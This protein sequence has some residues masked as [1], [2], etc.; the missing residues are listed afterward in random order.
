LSDR[1]PR[2]QENRHIDI[3]E[4]RPHHLRKAHGPLFEA[5]DDGT[6]GYGTRSAQAYLR[7]VIG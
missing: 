6:V 1:P 7:H 3:T 2:A 5:N 4:R